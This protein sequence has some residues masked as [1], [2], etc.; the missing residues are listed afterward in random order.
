[1]PE[2]TPV[3]LTLRKLY[4]SENELLRFPYNYFEGFIQLELLNVAHNHLVAIPPLGWIT[5]TLIF[6]NLRDN[7]I[8]S[9]DSMSVKTPFK[10]LHTVELHENKI[11]EFD[12]RMLRKMPKLTYLLLSG[13]CIQQIDDYQCFYIYRHGR[14]SISPNPFH[15]NTKMAWIS[16]TTYTFTDEPTCATPWCLKG[17]L[18]LGMSE[19]FITMTTQERRVVSNHRKTRLFTKIKL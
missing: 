7:N 3:K 4:L 9:L 15:C 16:N 14:I 1:M 17:R 10:K 8:T 2:L 19:Y 12:V 18:M 6:L 11:H 13:N 5:S